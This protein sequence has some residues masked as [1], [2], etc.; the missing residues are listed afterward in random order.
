MSYSFSIVAFIIGFVLLVPS[1]LFVR[2]SSKVADT[3]GGSYGRYQIYSYVAVGVSILI[4]FNIHALIG[5]FL[6]EN[7]F[8]GLGRS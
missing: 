2:Y 5:G 4:M 7:L 1:V 3:F 6:I 8:G